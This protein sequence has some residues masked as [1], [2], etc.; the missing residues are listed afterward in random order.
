MDRGDTEEHGAQRSY[1]ACFCTSAQSEMVLS[2]RKLCAGVME[3]EEVLRMA[4]EAGLN[5][6][7]FTEAL[8]SPDT[9][10][11]ASSLAA[12]CRC[13]ILSSYQFLIL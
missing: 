3:E 8:Q 13:Q 7:A 12:A 4:A 11:L 9:A 6:K 2:E 10:G 1:E 5:E